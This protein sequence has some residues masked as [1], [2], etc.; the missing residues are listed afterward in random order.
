MVVGVAISR[1][2][3]QLVEWALEWALE[4]VAVAGKVVVS[5]AVEPYPIPIAGKVGGQVVAF[6]VA[7]GSRLVGRS[8]V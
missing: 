1:R 4:W 5:R 3:G 8:R 2:L 7:V 6:R